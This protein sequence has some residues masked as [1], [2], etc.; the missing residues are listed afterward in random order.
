MFNDNMSLILCAITLVLFFVGAATGILA[1]MFY[2]GCIIIIYL[3]VIAN[4]LLTKK[5]DDDNFFEK[6][7]ED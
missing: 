6:T 7:I 2:V 4:F 1:N 3:L 5:H